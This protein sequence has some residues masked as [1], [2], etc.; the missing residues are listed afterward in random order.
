MTKHSQT[1]YFAGRSQFQLHIGNRFFDM[2]SCFCYYSYTYGLLQRTLSLCLTVKLKSLFSSQRDNLTLPT[3][4]QLQQKEEINTP[5][6]KAG[7]FQK[8]FARPK[9]RSFWFLIASLSLCLCL[10]LSLFLCLSQMFWHPDPDKMVTMSL[11]SSWSASFSNKVIFF[12]L[13]PHLLDLSACF[14]GTW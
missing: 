14:S 9:P 6:P 7:P 3:W 4:E 8:C 13:T 12:A 2:F 1:D 10:C 11:P 5:L